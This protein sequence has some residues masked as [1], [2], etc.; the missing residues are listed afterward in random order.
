M[1]NLTYYALDILKTLNITGNKDMV[2]VKSIILWNY[3][4]RET[5]FHKTVYSYKCLWWTISHKTFILIFQLMTS[6]CG[7]LVCCLL[8]DIISSDWSEWEYALHIHSTELWACRKCV[9]LLVLGDL[10]VCVDQWEPNTKPNSEALS[11]SQKSVFSKTHNG[12]L[13]NGLLQFP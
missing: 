11:L 12:L 6:R 4:H 7:M 3:Y 8:W 10:E 1:K 9:S 2:A 5:P 13:H